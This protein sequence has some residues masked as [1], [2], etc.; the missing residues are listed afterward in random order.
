MH[1]ISS[2]SILCRAEVKNVDDIV[3]LVIID[4]L[5]KR[6]NNNM[7]TWFARKGEIDLALKKLS[8]DSS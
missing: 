4:H 1:K 7:P 8:K 5:F 3:S 2:F 6:I